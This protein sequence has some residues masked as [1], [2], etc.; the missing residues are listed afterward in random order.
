MC[1]AMAAKTLTAGQKMS[2]G[3]TATSRTGPLVPLVKGER[4]EVDYDGQPWHKRKATVVSTAAYAEYDES[5][6]RR[7]LFKDTQW[8]LL[9]IDGI[10]GLTLLPVKHF[11]RTR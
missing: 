4:G 7:E 5:P 2:L 11:K 8:V 9:E 1:A 6:S 10:G 3:N